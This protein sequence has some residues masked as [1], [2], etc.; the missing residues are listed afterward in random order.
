MILIK[1]NQLG[2]EKAFNHLRII[3]E[4][5]PPEKSKFSITSTLRRLLQEHTLVWRTMD[6]MELVN[7][8]RKFFWN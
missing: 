8:S 1:I 5:L 2:E 6:E 4:I 3:D 7:S